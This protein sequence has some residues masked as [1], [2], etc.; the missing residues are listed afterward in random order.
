M[1]GALAKPALIV[2]ETDTVV[3]DPEA[4]NKWRE[5]QPEPPP[6]TIVYEDEAILVINKPAGLTVH[7]GSGVKSRTLVE[8]LRDH[9][10]DNLADSDSERPGIVHRLDRDTQ[11]LMII[12]KTDEA[13]AHLKAQFQARKIVKK[14]AARVTGVVAKD[15]VDIDVPIGRHRNQRTLMTTSTSAIVTPKPAQTLVT[16]KHRWTNQTLIEARPITGRTHQIRVHL[17]AIGHPVIGD[18]LYNKHPGKD[19]ALALQAVYLK[20]VHPLTQ[21]DMEFMLPVSSDIV[22]KSEGSFS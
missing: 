6:L 18:V 10:G 20:F 11:G 4:G 1:N 5:G 15:T 17:A 2:K 13:L 3:V 12:A 22:G 14:Y 8:S 19:N 7:P 21:Q 9:A 16:V